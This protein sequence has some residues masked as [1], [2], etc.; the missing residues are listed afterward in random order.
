M[1]TLVDEGV[2]SVVAGTV[3]QLRENLRALQDGLE[4][5]DTLDRRGTSPSTVHTGL[6]VG[7]LAP[8]SGGRP[9]IPSGGYG[10]VYRVA[11][12]RPR[13]GD[14]VITPEPG[15]ANREAG[16]T[17]VET[18]DAHEVRIGFPV[19]VRSEEVRWELHGDV[20]EV[21]YLGRAF[22]YYSAFLVPADTEPIV[23]WEGQSLTFRFTRL[24]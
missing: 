10:R 17:I 13:R 9:T 6:R 1:R 12:G 21:E 3:V 8:G 20:L 2:G 14:L 16:H 5:L 7:T 4:G 15:G 11:G 23:E 18:E 22:S 24:T 19:S